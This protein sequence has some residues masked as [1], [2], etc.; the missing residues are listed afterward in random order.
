MIVNTTYAVSMGNCGQL[1][2]P[3][4][5]RLSQ[6]WKQGANLLLVEMENEVILVSQEQA[7]RVLRDQ[8]KGSS[9][10]EELASDHRADAEREARS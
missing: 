1:V 6:D 9:L 10:V 3:Q 2:V 4:D 7:L 5:L 8:L